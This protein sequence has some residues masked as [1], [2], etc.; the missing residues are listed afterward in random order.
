V[1]Q[2][3]VPRQAVKQHFVPRQADALLGVQ[4]DEIVEG[5]PPAPREPLP[6]A[7]REKRRRDAMRAAGACVNG[8]SHGRA[9]RGGRCARCWARKLDGERL[10]PDLT[11]E[12]VLARGAA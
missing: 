1:K 2:H 5:A 7:A 10:G 8:W 6:R 4:L 12:M 3:F 11:D 9:V